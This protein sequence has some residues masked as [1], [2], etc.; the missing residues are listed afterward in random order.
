M[1]DNDEE[2]DTPNDEDDLALGSTYREATTTRREHGYS[3][4]DLVS[5]Y[6][7]YLQQR[8]CFHAVRVILGVLSRCDQCVLPPT[9]RV[10]Y[11]WH[12]LMLRKMKLLS[13][14]IVRTIANLV[15]TWKNAL[16]ISSIS[17]MAIR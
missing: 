12:M 16:L 3:H 17:Y 13:V 1:T 4:Q 15:R 8:N 5:K 14:A 9:C 2:N 11:V 10:P 6:F 7:T